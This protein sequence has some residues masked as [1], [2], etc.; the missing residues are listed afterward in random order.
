[1]KHNEETGARHNIVLMW[2]FIFTQVYDVGF[3]KAAIRVGS[4]YDQDLPLA[5]ILRGEVYTGVAHTNS[6]T[7]SSGYHSIPGD[8]DRN[9]MSWIPELKV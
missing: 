1:M 2:H 3:W 7:T 5:I 9:T 4:S 8:K 6:W